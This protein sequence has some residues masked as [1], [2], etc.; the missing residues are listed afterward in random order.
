VGL[1]ATTGHSLPRPVCLICPPPMLSRSPFIEPCLPSPAERPPSG[2]DWIHE[3]KHDGYRLMAR[4]DRTGIR[5]LT[6]NGY[7]WATRY[8][9]IIEAVNALNVRSVWRVL[10]NAQMPATRPRPLPGSF[11]ALASLVSAGG[12]R[13]YRRSTGNGRQLSPLSLAQR[14]ALLAGWSILC[15]VVSEMYLLARRRK[16]AATCAHSYRLFARLMRAKQDNAPRTLVFG[17]E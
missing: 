2:A 9:L 8:P 17:D 6:R 11:R 12:R 7:N 1:P 15:A 16:H 13:Q 4:R 14:A 3:I 10:I 5:L